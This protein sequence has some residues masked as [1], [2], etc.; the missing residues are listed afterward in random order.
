MRFAPLCQSGTDS[1]P[2]FGQDG[3]DR[4]QKRLMAAFRAAP[5][6]IAIALSLFGRGHAIAFEPNSELADRIA[7]H[8]DL[9]VKASKA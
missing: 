6:L 2:T 5:P 1:K 9:R 3:I 8:P 7:V 4:Y